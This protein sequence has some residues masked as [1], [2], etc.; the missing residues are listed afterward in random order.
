[1][2]K[3]EYENQKPRE[4]ENPTFTPDDTIDDNYEAIQTDTTSN[5][6]Q[7]KAEALDTSSLQKKSES[8]KPGS[9]SPQGKFASHR[10]RCCVTTVLITV[11]IT[12]LAGIGLGVVIGKNT[13]NTQ[14][15]NN[16]LE[17]KHFLHVCF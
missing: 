9:N 11:L 6:S 7:K 16:A 3:K 17:S 13:S 4:Y 2:D 5:S 15:E 10:N 14:T 1:M 12:L 8:C